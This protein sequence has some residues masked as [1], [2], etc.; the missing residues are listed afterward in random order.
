MPE[1]EARTDA[2][3]I[4]A[5]TA[6]CREVLASWA[7]RSLEKLYPALDKISTD[8]HHPYVYGLVAHTHLLGETVVDLVEAGKSLQALPLV[9]MMYECAL[10][11]QWAVLNV[12]APHAVANE[13]TRLQRATSSDMAQ[14]KNTILQEGAASLPYVDEEQLESAV[15]QAARHFRQLCVSL[16]PGG[17]ESYVYYRLLSDFGHASI[18]VSDAWLRKP[19]K[20][21]VVAVYRVQPDQS[22]DGL[23]IGF[24]LW[25]LIWA[26][27]ALD[28]LTA[29]RPRRRELDEFARAAGIP[30][31]LRLNPQV[32]QAA[33]AARKKAKEQRRREARMQ[34]P[35][36]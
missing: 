6:A 28:Y 21:G 31:M 2:R 17:I 35:R 19:E 10:T 11:A 7:G 20:E 34:R 9:R 27:T 18:R 30:A 25:S 4:E 3:E 8:A 29:G 33:F 12:D 24:C 32:A 15:D 16:E 23:A 36:D 13:M 14:A 1:E 22:E 5:T 26:G